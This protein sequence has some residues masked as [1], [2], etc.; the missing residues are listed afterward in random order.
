MRAI[1]KG[2][3]TF[4][5]VR[6]PVNL[7]AATGG[8][9]LDLHQVHD[10]DG[11]R[12]RYQRVCESCGQTISMDHICKAYEAQGQRVVITE[13]EMAGLPVSQS[14]DIEV[15]EFVEADDVDPIRYD[16]AYYLE[17][18]GPSLKAYVLLREAL[19]SSD[20]TAICHFSLRQKTR[21]AALRVHDEVLVLQSL[22][23]DDEV[24]TAD[25]PAL[26]ADVAI[27]RQEIEMS[28]LL[29]DSLSH[30]FTPEKYSDD[31]QVQLRQLLEQKLATGSTIVVQAPAT[32]ARESGEVID[33]VEALRRSV[34]QVQSEADGQPKRA[35]RRRKTG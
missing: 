13:E 24:R 27:S 32:S 30:P 25:F 33:L 8:H 2:A 26:R 22:L 15:V 20:R 21:L 7:Y 6:V 17:P 19:K 3:V 23:W 29:V 10:A 18:D 4:G 35:S 11:G 1:W 12:I 34:E 28:K 16:R 9:D 14:R 5:L 31:Y